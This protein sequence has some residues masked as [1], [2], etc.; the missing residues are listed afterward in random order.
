MLWAAE[1]VTLEGY[2]MRCLLVPPTI[3][4]SSENPFPVHGILQARILEW[5]AIPF[6]RDLPSLEIKP[7]SL[8]LQADSLPSEPPEKPLTCSK[9]KSSEMFT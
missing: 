4:K 7:R 6:S 8:A 1:L 3:L 9:I 5:V 2:G